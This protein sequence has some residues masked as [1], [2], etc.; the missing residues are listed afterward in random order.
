MRT[1]VFVLAMALVLLASVCGAG[2]AKT[3]GMTREACEKVLQEIKIPPFGFWLKEGTLK[4]IYTKW[5]VDN[6]TGALTEVEKYNVTVLRAGNVIRT[7]KIYAGDKDR[8][9]PLGTTAEC[10][11]EAP[12]TILHGVIISTPDIF[13]VG[14]MPQNSW[15]EDS[16]GT[17]PHSPVNIFCTAGLHEI[18][19]LDQH[20]VTGERCAG[21][22]RIVISL[23]EGQTELDI[24]NNGLLVR[25]LDE[26]PFFTKTFDY[27][28][29]GPGLAKVTVLTMLRQLS[30]TKTLKECFDHQTVDYR[31]PVIETESPYGGFVQAGFMLNGKRRSVSYVKA[32][33]WE[34]VLAD[35]KFYIQK[36][37]KLNCA[38]MCARHMARTLNKPIGEDEEPLLD[39]GV[40][41]GLEI[42]SSLL[43]KGIQADLVQT[44]SLV[45][46]SILHLARGERQHFVSLHAV[47][48]DDVLLADATAGRCLYRVPKDLLGELGW[49]GIAIVPASNASSY[50]K[51]PAD[52]DVI[53]G[54]TFYPDMHCGLYIP[55]FIYDCPTEAGPETCEG[56]RFLWDLPFWICWYTGDG[57][58][59][60]TDTYLMKIWCDCIYDGIPTPCCTMDFN[61]SWKY[62][63]FACF[64]ETP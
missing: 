8:I 15:F 20:N 6:E 43:A 41:S 16:T 28:W 27:E 32:P 18:P 22:S 63:Q 19:A 11:K 44:T 40:S 9:V 39:A 37:G 49:N 55:G 23:N 56:Y 21:Y 14:G 30:G 7:D 25:R 50:A 35:R 17:I 1:T 52:F 5:S 4:T 45:P 33:G 3:V 29:K 12:G 58:Y 2:T 48:E 24:A 60:P 59:V 36:G 38:A 62:S 64:G 42:V 51:L 53:G 34:S 57:C 26:R 31:T 54:G 47:R 13:K 61:F 10:G 46:G